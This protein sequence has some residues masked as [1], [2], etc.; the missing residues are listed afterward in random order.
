MS[1]NDSVGTE[2]A[3]AAWHKQI[4]EGRAV[5]SAEFEPTRSRHA[6]ERWGSAELNML[7]V[8]KLLDER[9]AHEGADAVEGWWSGFWVTIDHVHGSHRKKRFP[10]RRKL[11][12]VLED[13]LHQLCSADRRR[14]WRLRPR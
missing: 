7:Q 11:G 2:L 12:V 9:R 6:E 13:E 14:S 8:Y 10:S 3:A 4:S 5:C 1:A